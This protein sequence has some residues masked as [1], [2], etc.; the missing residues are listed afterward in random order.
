MVFIHV[1][2][3]LFQVINGEH[4]GPQPGRASLGDGCGTSRGL[5]PRPLGF[6]LRCS[7]GGRIVS[8][9]PEASVSWTCDIGI[10]MDTD[11][12]V[13]VDIDMDHGLNPETEAD[14]EAE[15]K[16]E[17]ETKRDSDRDRETYTAC[18]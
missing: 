4:A 13:D 3:D 15:A 17:A 16:I 7:D 5:Q 12:D 2:T 6:H 11:I 14:A 18:A 1:F 8:H 10:D 9:R